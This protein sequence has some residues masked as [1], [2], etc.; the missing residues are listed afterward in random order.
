VFAYTQLNFHVLSIPFLPVAT[1]GT[2]VAFYAG[3]KNNASYERLWEGRKIWA[4]IEHLCRYSAMIVLKSSNP[5]VP[6][7]SGQKQFVYGLIAW[8]NVLRGH[9][10]H[11]HTFF[12]DDS[13]K[14]DQ[15][16]ILKDHEGMVLYEEDMMRSM[17][18]ICSESEAREFLGKANLPVAILFKQMVMLDSLKNDGG[19]SESDYIKLLDLMGACS[20]QASAAERLNTFPFP[21]Q[22]AHFSALF[23]KIFVVLLPFALIT[24]LKTSGVNLWLTVPFSVLVSW[25]FFTMERVGDTSEN[26]FENAL[27]DVPLSTICRD[28]EIDLKSMLGEVDLPSPLLPQQYVML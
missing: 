25:V 1:V 7:S 5:G 28:I 20:Q 16:R 24:E 22:Y 19:L 26:P 3:F 4:E 23:V 10:R 14:R 13:G 15:A 9:L 6:L 27:N 12:G 17:S 2:A 21:R 11:I 18:P 8:A